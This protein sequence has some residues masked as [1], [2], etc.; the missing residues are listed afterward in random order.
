[1]MMQS[2][3]NACF[4]PTECVGIGELAKQALIAEVTLTPKPGLVDNRNTGSH[5]DL[6][7]NLMLRSASCLAPFFA[8]M[9]QVALGQPVSVWLREQIGAIGRNAEVAMMA[10]TQGVNTHR[11]AIWAL[12]LL[13]TAAMVTDS[14]NKTA[15]RLCA[16]AGQLASLADRHAPNTFSKGKLASNHFQ[17]NGAKQ[18]AQ[19][20]FPAVTDH[21][22]PT[23][24]LSRLRG[25]SETEARL[26][27][28]LA[29]TAHLTDTC[30]LSRAGLAGQT[31]LQ[32]R[33][34]DILA[35]GGVS[36]P[37]GYALLEQLDADMIALNASP[38]GAADLLAATLFVDWVEHS[39]LS[40]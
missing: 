8:E 5:T 36:H 14:E 37:Q 28:L 11:G 31:H 9:A 23:L 2:C 17:V 12:G 34:R 25:H 30:V 32:T 13:S 7:V 15:E 38:G 39:E 40:K 22:L 20:G 3:Q 33:S 4:A 10:T 19:L 16:L 26:N 29:L 35:L 27:A 24:R 21:A 18:Q 6:T 1:M